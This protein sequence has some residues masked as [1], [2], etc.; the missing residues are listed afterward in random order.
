M[1]TMVDNTYLTNNLKALLQE[2]LWLLDDRL[3]QKRMGSPYQTFT[4]AHARIFA[5]LRGESLTISEVARRL[6]V[7]RQA[8]HKLVST[9]V[10]EGLLKLDP[11]PNN[12]RDKRIVFTPKGDALKREAAKALQEL[13]QEVQNAIGEQ[14]FQL[15]KNLLQKQW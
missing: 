4:D 6:N 9:L 11:L 15:L 14:N 5:T 13:E 8:V 2:K 3:K 7:S 1:S 12:A 10:K